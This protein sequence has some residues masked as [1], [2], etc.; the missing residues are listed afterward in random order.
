M[1][2]KSKLVAELEAQA[3]TTLTPAE[4]RLVRWMDREY[5]NN[6]HIRLDKFFAQL[7]RHVREEGS[8]R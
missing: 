7:R 6:G 8:R 3:K 5:T 2:K 1:G 4:V